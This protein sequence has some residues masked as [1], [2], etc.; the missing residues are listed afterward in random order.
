MQVLQR[1]PQLQSLDGR[2][3]EPA[4]RAAVG[5]CLRHEAAIMT[6]MLANANL[7]H[8]LL[9]AMVLHGTGAEVS[10]TDGGW[11]RCLPLTAAVLGGGLTSCA[12]QRLVLQHMEVHE[13]LLLLLRP[14]H[15]VG[16]VPVPARILQ[17]WSLEQHQTLT[18]SR[19]TTCGPPSCWPACPGTPLSLLACPQHVLPG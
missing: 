4:E 7:A 1:L 3:V 17:L 9:R 11:H 16:S 10:A 8:K 12:W 19:C 6:L 15:E 2:D 13:E 5:A 18:V 14:R